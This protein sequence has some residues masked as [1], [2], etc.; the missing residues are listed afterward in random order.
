MAARDG[1]AGRRRRALRRL[2]VHWKVVEDVVPIGGAAAHERR[3][4]AL[5]S[6]VPVWIRARDTTISILGPVFGFMP[7]HW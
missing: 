1:G 7:S 6:I 2:W 4:H 3:R 5:R